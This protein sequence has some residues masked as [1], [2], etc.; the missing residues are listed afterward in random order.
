MGL[1]KRTYTDQETVITAENMNAIQDSVI[2]LEDGVFMRAASGAPVVIADSSNNKLLGLN[3][4]GKSTQASVPTPAAPVDIVSAGDDGAIKCGLFGKNIFDASKLLLHTNTNLSVLDDGYTI[5]ATGGK[6]AT[7]TNSRYNLPL[8][9]KGQSLFLA[10]DSIA[11]SQEVDVSA[12]VMV[13]TPST[14]YY[15]PV[16][17]S[18]S[19]ISFTVPIDATSVSLGIYTNNTSTALSTDNTVTVKGLRLVL[20]ANKADGWTKAVSDQAFSLSHTLRGVPVTDASYAT[21]TDASGKM[22]CADEIDLSRGVYIQRVKR[23]EL[24]VANMNNLEE[25]PGWKDI[26]GLSECFATGTIGLFSYTS[27][28]GTK[29]S[30]NTSSLNKVLYLGQE[31]YGMTQ[32]QWKENYPD[33]VCVFL[34][35]LTHPVE[36]TLTAAEIASYKA[37]HTN[38]PNTIAFNDENAYMS[39]KYIADAKAYIDHRLSN[40]SVKAAVALPASAWVGSGNIYSQVVKIDG[41][42]K[43]SQVNLTPSISQMATFYEK[44]ITFI[45]ENDSGVVT[46][47]VIGQKPANDYTIQASIVEVNV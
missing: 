10:I 11:T 21:Y 20:S 47:Y 8:S 35:P 27:N 32:T 46:V 37:L 33:L 19:S 3:V 28:V 34:F 36:T 45:T 44:D 6:G 18:R 38:K 17:R 40:S 23:I 9:L 16:T 13:I 24:S 43:N 5:I 39:V 26:S 15:H 7:Y 31:T 30:I 41:V 2:A 1:E 42:T 22:W 25:Y 4:Y 12:Q 14:T 29:Q